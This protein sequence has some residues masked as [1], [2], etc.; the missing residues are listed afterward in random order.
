MNAIASRQVVKEITESQSF[1]HKEISDL[2]GKAVEIGYS[3][4]EPFQIG[5][6]AWVRESSN[7]NKDKTDFLAVKEEPYDKHL[8]VS[9]TAPLIALTCDLEQIA[10]QV[11][12][13]KGVPKNSRLFNTLAFGGV[14]LTT[15]LA[16][17]FG[18]SGSSDPVGRIASGVA[19]G[20][21]GLFTS[22]MMVGSLSNSMQT[23]RYTK[24][25]EQ[26]SPSVFDY[27]F[28]G[29]ASKQFLEEHSSQV[30]RAEIYDKIAS[31]VVKRNDF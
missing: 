11:L 5:W 9:G 16:A 22:L 15:L 29:E 12:P 21:I 28:G 20:V 19:G 26:L 24:A 27:R 2:F 10:S 6:Q 4:L 17:Y 14:S 30:Y 7:G 1:T 18:I 31:G 3:Q 25:T 23:S 13:L 8:L